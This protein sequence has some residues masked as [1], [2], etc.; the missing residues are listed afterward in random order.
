MALRSL[1]NLPA[2]ARWQCQNQRIPAGDDEKGR[3]EEAPETAGF[4]SA[5]ASLAV[6][7]TTNDGERRREGGSETQ[8][9]LLTVPV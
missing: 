4:S 1:A 8:E 7:A 3:M 2:R 5:R 9:Q 6:T